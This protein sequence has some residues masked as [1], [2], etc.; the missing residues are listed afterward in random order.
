MYINM[1]SSDTQ[2]VNATELTT[3]DYNYAKPTVNKSGGKS[4]RVTGANNKGSLL[5]STP[6]M[7][8]WG[9]N[10][11]I[12]EQSGRR[13]YDLSLQFPK[14]EYKTDATTAFLDRILAFQEQVKADALTHSKEWLN[15]SK[16][17]PEVIDALFHPMVRYPK[18]QSTGEPDTSR[19]PTFR[20]KLGYWDD[21]FD[22]EIY[23]MN[24]EALFPNTDSISPVDLIPKGTMIATVLRCG[25][26]WNANGKF[27]CTWKL[28]QAVVQPRASLKGRCLIS[29]SAG[30]KDTLKKQAA[31]ENDGDSDGDA[32]GVEITEDTDDENDVAEEVAEEVA[33]PPTPPPVKKTVKKKV[34]RKSKAKGAE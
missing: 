12:D 16:T 11:Y 9:V 13:S 26:I 31:A 4:I 18:D 2:I 27:G 5:L 28:V 20:I 3:G 32:V 14:D 33:A 17:S 21:A 23:D 10:E 24:Q 6:L 22:C 30:E 29:L 34:V 1:S 15:K 19:A 8:T 7:L 25:G